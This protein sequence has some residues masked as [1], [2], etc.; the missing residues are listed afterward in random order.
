MWSFSSAAGV[1]GVLGMIG[2]IVASCQLRFSYHTD[3]SLVLRPSIAL[4]S[5]DAQYFTL[6]ILSSHLI[7]DWNY[8]YV[9]IAL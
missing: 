7:E 2:D 4:Q 8:L 9:S 3:F 6:H 5:S 1:S